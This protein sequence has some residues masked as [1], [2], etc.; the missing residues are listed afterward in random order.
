MVLGFVMVYLSLENSSHFL[1]AF[2]FCLLSGYLNW[3]I[4]VSGFAFHFITRGFPQIS[5]FF[6][7]SFKFLIWD[8]ALRL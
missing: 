4:K 2:Q 3:E 8:L 5:V 7:I 6:L 1:F